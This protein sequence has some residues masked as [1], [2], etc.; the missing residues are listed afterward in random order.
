MYLLWQFIMKYFCAL[1]ICVLLTSCEDNSDYTNYATSSYQETKLTLEEQEQQ[2]PAQFLDANGT[3][4]KN[5]VG[6]WVMEGNISSSASVATYKDVVLNINFISA[7]GT[8][9]G[10]QQETIYKYVTPGGQQSFKVKVGGYRDAE[11]VNMS[12]ISAA[13][14]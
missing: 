12:V 14:Q 3:Y 8:E 4:R 5:L 2:S 1:S 9:I 13:A 6:E 11:S 10:S 7:T